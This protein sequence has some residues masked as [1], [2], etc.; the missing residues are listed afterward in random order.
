MP[1]ISGIGLRQIRIAFF[2]NVE[3]GLD[4]LV[5]RGRNAFENGVGLSFQKLV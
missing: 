1:K 4:F 3:S 2:W 5:T